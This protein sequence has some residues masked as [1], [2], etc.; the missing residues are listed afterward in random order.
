MCHK[1]LLCLEKQYLPQE[2][3]KLPLL[4]H[5]SS[6]RKIEKSDPNFVDEDFLICEVKR[7]E[8]N[9][10]EVNKVNSRLD[11]FSSTDVSNSSNNDLAEVAIS[12][13]KLWF[14]SKDVV[15]ATGYAERLVESE[16]YGVYKLE[17]QIQKWN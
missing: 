16:D 1:S 6:Y 4:K 2:G 3:V 12:T 10:F 11:L 14:S 13:T 5:T 9:S 15:V 8:G 7:T 17:I